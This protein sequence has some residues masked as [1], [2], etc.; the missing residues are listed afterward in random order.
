MEKRERRACRHTPACLTCD[1]GEA[2]TNLPHLIN[3]GTE[4]YLQLMLDL[5]RPVRYSPDEWARLV[6]ESYVQRQRQRGAL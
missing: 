6:L 4:L 3:I 2:E 5:A 1:S